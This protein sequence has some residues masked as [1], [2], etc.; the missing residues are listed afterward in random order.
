VAVR[1]V[2][3]AGD[4]AGAGPPGHKYIQSPG[5]GLRHTNFPN[6]PVMR[7]LHLVVTAVAKPCLFTVQC[8]VRTDL[9]GAGPVPVL[10]QPDSLPGAEVELAVGE[11]HRQVGA[12][13]AG[14][15]VGRL[16]RTVAA[17]QC[18]GPSGLDEYIGQ[19]ALMGKDSKSAGIWST[20]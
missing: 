15:H 20:F 3:W 16:G 13:E 9:S 17:E 10:A 11:R 5:D 4:G 14:F 19:I 1:A 18:K 12:E 6:F 8:S 2:G 7:P